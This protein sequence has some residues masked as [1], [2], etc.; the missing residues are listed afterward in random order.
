M[1]TRIYC[2][3]PREKHKGFVVI[4]IQ[5]SQLSTLLHVTLLRSS[6]FIRCNISNSR[7]ATSS[8]STVKIFCFY[9]W[10]SSA[11]S[12]N[13]VNSKVQKSKLYQLIREDRQEGWLMSLFVPWNIHFV[14]ILRL[15]IF[16]WL[17]VPDTLGSSHVPWFHHSHFWITPRP[18]EWGWV[19]IAPWREWKVKPMISD[20]PLVLKNGS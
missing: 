16:W 10:V 14:C 20:W 13:S 12:N 5:T 17:V 8:V 15:S 6:L 3:N 19:V 2:K 11:Q 9:L 4:C 1:N 7:L 18:W